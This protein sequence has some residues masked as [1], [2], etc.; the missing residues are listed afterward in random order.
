MLPRKWA[1]CGRAG[2]DLRADVGAP[3]H[4]VGRRFDLLA[5]EE[6]LALLVA[7]EVDHP[8]AVLA[9]RLGDREQHGVAET[10]ARQQHVSRRAES[11][12]ACRSAPSR[13]P[14]RPAADR[15]T[16]G[17]RRPSRA[18]SAT[19][20]PSRDRPRRRSARCLPSAAAARRGT[21]ARVR[22]R[23]EVLQAIELAGLKCR[24]AAGA[25]TTTSTMVGVRR[26][27]YSTVR[28]QVARRGVAP[29]RV[30]AASRIGCAAG[31]RRGS[32]RRRAPPRAR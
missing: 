31:S 7:G 25:C 13:R 21:L 9:Q 26:S 15:R 3:D 8:V 6:I 27:T 29:A 28:Q 22:Q 30:H 10:A 14:A 20:A 32:R 5:L 18:R 4:L 2:V 17:S 23:L 11:R 1:S 16:A 19:A 24:A 12:L